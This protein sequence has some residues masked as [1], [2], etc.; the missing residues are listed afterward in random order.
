MKIPC[1]LSLLLAALTAWAADD[2]VPGPDSLPQPGVPR[3]QVLKFSLDDSKIFPGTHRN[4]WVYVPAQYTPDQPA[5][6]YVAQDNVNFNAPTVF[7]NLIAKHELPVIIGVFVAPGVVPAANPEA[8]LNRYNRSYEFDGLGDNYVRFLLEELLPQVEKITLPDGR[9]IHLSHEAKDRAIGGSSTG[10]IAAFTAAWERPDAFSRVFTSIGTFV[11]FRG[12]TRYPSLIRKFEPKPLR[13]F[14]QDGTNDLNHY[15]GDWHTENVMMERALSFAGYEVNHVWGTGGH[16]A[17]QA[18]AIFPDAMRWLWAGWPAPVKAGASKNETLADILIPGNDWQLVSAGHRFTE[19][20]AVNAAGEVFYNDIP[21]SKTFKVARD[22]AVSLFLTNSAHANGQAFGP[23]GRLYANAN[24]H[25]EVIA[26]DAN[27]QATVV[28]TNINGNDIVVAHNGNIYVTEPV[29]GAVVAP[30]KVWLI[31]PDGSKQVVDTG[32]KF[33]NG[34]GLT[35][36]QS[37]LYVDDTRSHWVYSFVIQP[38]GTLADKQRFDWLN[39]R[40]TDD[41]SGADGLRCDRTG[42]LYVATRLGIQV[43]DQIGRVL[44]ILPTPNGKV[45]NLTFGGEKFDTLYATC[46]D[47][48]Y[49]RKLNTT[50]ANSCAAP[51]KP[52]TPRL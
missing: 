37:L 45:A 6:L 10:A 12:G 9:A 33:A 30:S 11:D 36:D 26:Y 47:K 14:M 17:K 32:L 39:V 29:G 34:I 35:P 52:N 23:D 48:V 41:D 5:C 49:R 22:G 8:A 43:C 1:F 15:G 4:Y 2:Y 51:N 44:C 20:P 46:G 7:D 25:R 27:G 31:R 3:G 18:T 38:D 24:Q 19:G 50:G 16:S 28:A 40:D 21:A 42:R 13:I